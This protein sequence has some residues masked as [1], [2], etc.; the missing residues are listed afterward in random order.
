[1]HLQLHCVLKV[2]YVPF[3][4]IK[5]TQLCTTTGICCPDPWTKTQKGDEEGPQMEVDYKNIKIHT[6]GEKKR[7]SRYL[8][9]R[10]Q[11]SIEKF[12]VVL[13]I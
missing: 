9:K 7:S 2:I 4:L 8:Y 11:V 1:M 5:H 6:F 13:H 3:R 10:Q 12:V